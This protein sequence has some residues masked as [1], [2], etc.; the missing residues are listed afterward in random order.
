MRA[1][2]P[3]SFDPLTNGHMDLIERAVA[4]FGQV[5]VA[6]LSNPNKKPAFSVDQRIGQIQC[7]TRHLNG[8]DVVSFDGLTVHCAV[9][10]QADLILR[11][12]RAMSDFEYELQ[13]AHTNRSLA[14]DLETV[15][16]ATSTRHSFL[17]SSVV[18]EVAR[19]GGPVDH[20]VPKEVA[21]DLNRL[22]NS[23]F[24]PR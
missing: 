4:L 3:G 17:S 9:T 18:K 6:V 12:L 22:F 10:H 16:L 21:K 19:F 11:G 5:T 2:Y 14:E 24:P 1:L 8:I 23:T 7:A 20:M 13:I 15:F